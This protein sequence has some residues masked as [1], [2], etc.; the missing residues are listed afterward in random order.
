MPAKA[1]I[2]A[3]DARA[4]QAGGGSRAGTCRRC[5]C[6]CRVDQAGCLGVHA[7]G[8]NAAAKER[9]DVAAGVQVDI[10][11]NAD[12][13]R[14]HAAI[15]TKPFFRQTLGVDRCG[16]VSDGTFKAEAA[17]VVTHAQLSGETGLC[18]D[19]LRHDGRR[20]CLSGSGGPGLW[21]FRQS[22]IGIDLHPGAR[23]GIR[24]GGL[25]LRKRRLCNDARACGD[26]HG[27]AADDIRVHELPLDA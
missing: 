8:A 4:S 16:I 14:L 23:H 27:E 7:R 12:V 9:I 18:I 21:R 15:R 2:P 20:W 6:R 11:G 3:V 25:G 1:P 19:A 13:Q 17:E 24:T 22:Q 5:S 26:S 10:A